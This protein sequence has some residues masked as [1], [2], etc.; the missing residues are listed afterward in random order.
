MRVIFA[1]LKGTLCRY[2]ALQLAEGI[3]VMHLW[4]GEVIGDVDRTSRNARSLDMV[5]RQ[6]HC[7]FLT[8]TIQIY[9]H[10]PDYL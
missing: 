5:R 8:P 10:T 9:L 6:H 3:S 4:T 7:F 2:A 1:V